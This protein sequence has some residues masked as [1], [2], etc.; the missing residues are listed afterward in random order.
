MNPDDEALLAELGDALAEAA[1]ADDIARIGRDLWAWH[2]PDAALAALVSDTAHTPTTG[3]RGPGE[4]RLLRFTGD[5][6]TVEAEVIDGHVR[7]LALGPRPVATVEAHAPHTQVATAQPD[8]TGWFDL[9]LPAELVDDAVL[10]RLRLVDT[11]DQVTWTSWFR[12]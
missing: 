5:E 8:Q 10:L 4:A 2:D 7:G 6:V 12:A 1:D 9:T 3:V 11:S